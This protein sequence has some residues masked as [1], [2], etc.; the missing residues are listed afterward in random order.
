M[1]S[2]VET[3][4][5][6]ISLSVEGTIPFLATSFTI[7]STIKVASLKISLSIEET[8]LFPTTFSAVS[9]TIKT[10]SSEIPLST[11]ETIS[12][13]EGIFSLCL[14]IA[15]SGNKR[16]LTVSLLFWSFLLV[17]SAYSVI[18][19]SKDITLLAFFL[20][21]HLHQLQCEDWQEALFHLML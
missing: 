3:A 13:S 8:I 19:S 16:I 11:K 2:L 17:I 5:S 9:S 6:E 18:C 12:F 20:K 7:S 14:L 15:S 10:A 4:S 1:S 21:Y